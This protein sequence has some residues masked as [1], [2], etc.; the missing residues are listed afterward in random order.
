[1]APSAADESDSDLDFDSCV[2]E[3]V[4]AAEIAASAPR[5]PP[6]PRSAAPR[7]MMAA[8]AAIEADRVS[9]RALTTPYADLVIPASIAVIGASASARGFHVVE[10]EDELRVFGEDGGDVAPL[11]RRNPTPFDDAVR[12]IEDGHLYYVRGPDG[13]FV[14]SA[15]VTSV[16][17]ICDH[18]KAGEFKRLDI[19][20]RSAETNFQRCVA[21]VRSLPL[22]PS[23]RDLVAALGAPAAKKLH[24]ADGFRALVRGRA[25]AVRARSAAA[26]FR[27]LAGA[28]AVV[29]GAAAAPPKRARRR[30]G[31]GASA[32]A[33]G[34][35]ALVSPSA[36][37]AAAADGGSAEFELAMVRRLV[38]AVPK[39]LARTFGGLTQGAVLRTWRNA[40]DRGTYMHHQLEL[41]YNSMPYDASSPEM[42]TIFP[43]L[44]A[45]HPMLSR[46]LVYRTEMSMVFP[47]LL[48]TGQLDALFH[49]TEFPGTFNLVDWKDKRD[50]YKASSV[51]REFRAAHPDV[52]ATGV[53]EGARQL[54]LYRYFLERAKIAVSGMYLVDIHPEHKGGRV[55]AVPFLPRQATWLLQKHVDWLDRESQ[56]PPSA[57]AAR[58]ECDPHAEGG[59]LDPCAPA[60]VPAGFG[61]FE[62]AV[63]AIDSDDDAGDPDWEEEDGDDSDSDWEEGDP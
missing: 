62:I 47:A 20:A 61:E 53:G 48:A 31:G 4:R 51:S 39:S 60:L 22:R 27:V 9:G 7:G 19:S 15:L 17:K 54:N 6:P 52:D 33:Q 41:Y 28:A 24:R 23:F 16:T 35:R 5:P 40:A 11:R 44:L 21:A 57:A 29:V 30:S 34:F 36:A 38:D 46:D 55:I 1:M 3:A 25:A 59:A 26:G 56:R 37:A 45:A 32:G 2:E 43:A 49:S 50:I 12:F 58:D 14:R 10:P 18:A 63:D 42:G 8:A 13:R